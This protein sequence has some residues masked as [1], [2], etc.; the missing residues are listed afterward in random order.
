MRAYRLSVLALFVTSAACSGEKSSTTAAAARDV[1]TISTA[2]DADALLPP[3]VQTTQGKQAVDMM[4][5]YL[6]EPVGIIQTVGDAGFRGSLARSWSWSRDSLSVA[7]SIDPRARWHDGA[8]VRAGDVRFSFELYVDPATASPHADDFK[9]IDS[10]SVRDSLTAVV[11]WKKRNPEQFFQIVYAL[12][13]LPQHLLQNEAHASLASSAFAQHPVG[14]G[15]YRF[16]QWTRNRQLVLIADSANFRGRPGFNRV[17]WV[18]A[19]DPTAATLTVLSGQADVLDQL[20]GDAFVKA[21][22]AP[23]IRTV[24]YGS[25]DYAYMQFNFER[26]VGRTARLFANRA[27]RVALSESLDRQSMVTNALDSLGAVALGPFT[28]SEFMADTTV[29]QLPF[30]LQLASHTLDSLG[31]KLDSKDS[32]RKKDGQPLQFELLVPSSSATRQKF[33]VLIQAQLRA[34][35]VKADVAPVEPGIFAS[36]LQK[37]DF[38]AALNMWHSDPSPTAIAA[39]WGSPHG[40]N[41]G[42]NYGRYANAAFDATVDS[43]VTSFNANTRRLL[44]QRAFQLIVDDAP[45]VWLYEPRNF[46]AVSARVT[47]VGLRPDAWWAAIPSWHLATPSVALKH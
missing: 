27:L 10:V 25:L 30:N 31:W 28:R 8:P 26:T 15:R 19:A 16:E 13:I 22:A 1:L 11:W 6:A 24:E 45:A 37:G 43:A 42:A 21:R 3:L 18:V 44:L 29:R 40:R 5:D 36:R 34:V 17:V 46:A 20:R 47:T 12:A 14:S 38:D 41:A 35:G 32:V 33:G 2:A 4:F 39:V 9:G 7:F 23:Q